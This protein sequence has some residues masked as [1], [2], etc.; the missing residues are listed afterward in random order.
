MGTGL[1]IDLA[2][3][4]AP[5]IMRNGGASRS[6]RDNSLS[7]S[8]SSSASPGKSNQQSAALSYQKLN[9]K[10]FTSL[11]IS[12]DEE[13]EDQELVF[14]SNGKPASSVSSK[15]SG[16]SNKY[17]SNGKTF[18]TNKTAGSD[19]KLSSDDDD[20]DEDSVQLNPASKSTSNTQRLIDFP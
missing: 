12:E 13:I 5:S 20:D 17:P 4:L 7:S 2:S 1:D 9:N 3:Q 16:K 8:Q 15:L 14:P 11:L 19:N 10:E 18:A 6:Y